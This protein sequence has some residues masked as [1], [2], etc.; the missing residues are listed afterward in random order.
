MYLG[1]RLTY[2]D[3]KTWYKPLDLRVKA[4]PSPEENGD[5]LDRACG[6]LGIVV[7]AMRITTI[8]GGRSV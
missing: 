1:L 7:E 8:S 5:I 3:G 6:S 2:T 4:E